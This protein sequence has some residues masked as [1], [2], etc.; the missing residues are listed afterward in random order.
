MPPVGPR[1]RLAGSP[2]ISFP[3]VNFTRRSRCSPIAVRRQ[4]AKTAD[5]ASAEVLPL[6]L[7]NVLKCHIVMRINASTLC[8]RVCCSMIDVLVSPVSRFRK[9]ETLMRFVLHGPVV[10]YGASTCETHSSSFQLRFHLSRTLAH[11]RLIAL[12]GNLQRH[13]S[14]SPSNAQQLAPSSPV[15]LCSAV[16]HRSRT[17]ALRLWSGVRKRCHSVRH[18]NDSIDHWLQIS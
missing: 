14:I 4:S 17:A 8:V 16:V 10:W 18:N 6:E 3:A 9:R 2:T 1:P 13:L 7:V 15:L 12:A 5:S 11:E